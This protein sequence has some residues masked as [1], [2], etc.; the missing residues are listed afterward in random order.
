MKVIFHGSLD[1]DFLKPKLLVHIQFSILLNGNF[2]IVFELLINVL[3]LSWLHFVVLSFIEIFLSNLHYYLV[4]CYIYI[5]TYR[6][7]N[8]KTSK[9]I[10]K[11]CRSIISTF[12]NF[13]NIKSFKCFVMECWIKYLSFHFKRPIWCV[14]K[15]F[16]LQSI[17]VI[18][19]FLFG[20]TTV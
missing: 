2:L 1:M 7:Q 9:Y 11:E 13:Q 16:I 15:Y 10:F 19:S 14:L 17:N 4:T 5:L 18:S 3:K 8:M 20:H 12:N 6:F